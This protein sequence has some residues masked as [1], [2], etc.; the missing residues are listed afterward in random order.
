MIH[1]L[2][3][4]PSR[5]TGPDLRPIRP[6][7]GD[8]QKVEESNPR[9]TPTYFPARST[10]NRRMRTPSL[11]RRS[12]RSNLHRS[13]GAC[14]I[15]GMRRLWSLETPRG[16]PPGT[17]SVRTSPPGPRPANSTARLPISIRSLSFCGKDSGYRQAKAARDA[18]AGWFGE[19]RSPGGASPRQPAE[20]AMGSDG[21]DAGRNLIGARRL[22]AGQ[23]RKHVATLKD[24]DCD[25]PGPARARPDSRALAL[26][27]NRDRA[28]RGVTRPRTARSPSRHEETNYSGILTPNRCKN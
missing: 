23:A 3:R 17:T 18:D 1:E 22:V 28:D 4:F 9:S 10:R 7:T 27:P 21:R 12:H 5:F 25:C 14:P 26:H 13:R 8:R 19:R 2:R 20:P 16:R 15:G 24:R 11:R 6:L